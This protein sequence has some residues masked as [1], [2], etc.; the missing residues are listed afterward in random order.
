MDSQPAL[1]RALG[2]I[3]LEVHNTQLRELVVNG[4]NVLAEFA[5]GHGRWAD[6][7]GKMVE[8]NTVETLSAAC[9]L[10]HRTDRQFAGWLGRLQSW[11]EQQTPLGIAGNR[12]VALVYETAPDGHI[13]SIVAFPAGR[14]NPDPANEL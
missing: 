6:S 12:T 13:V 2:K 14:Q 7:S 9:Y 3:R 10:P 1:E 5:G 8:I 11:Q 4:R